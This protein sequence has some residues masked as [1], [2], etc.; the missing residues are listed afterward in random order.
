[1]LESFY[2]FCKSYLKYRHVETNKYCNVILTGVPRSG[3]TLTCHLLNKLSNTVALHEPMKVDVFPR[4]GN[5][6]AICDTIDRFCKQTRR[7]III[8]KTAIT[9]HIDGVVPDNPC[10]DQ[11][12]NS[13]LRALLVSKGKISIKKE[14]TPDFVLVIKHPAAFTAI[15]ESL[16]KHFPCYAVIRN[17]LSVLASWNSVE[18][19]VANG[20]SHI[21]ERLDVQLAQALERIDEKIERQIYLLSWFY[22]KYHKVLPRESILRYEDIIFSEGKTLKVIVPQARELDEVL[23]NKNQN[24]L[25]NK[26]LMLLLG[27][28]LLNMDGAFWQFY[29]KESVEESMIGSA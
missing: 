5:G 10:G 7:S 19:A 14:L 18:M 15:L 21:A 25:Y 26:Q 20:H 6:D 2:S 12:S 9:R 17:P 1:M 8:R 29:S 24:K 23:E 27:E 22:E 28:K 3:T 4:L 13:G 16:I 11:F